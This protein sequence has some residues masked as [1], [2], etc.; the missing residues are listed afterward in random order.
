M[1][2]PKV[3]VIFGGCS[4]EYE[5]SLQSAAAVIPHIDRTKYEPVT[6]GITRNGEWFRF[7]G[8]AERIEAGAWTDGADCIPAVI[9]PDRAVR[10]LL[11]FTAGGVKAT[12]L[13]AAMPILHGRNGEDG[14]VQGLLELAGIP[15]VGC[16]AE[17]SAICMD[18]GRARKLARQ[19]GAAVPESFEICDGYDM[20]AMAIRAKSLGFPLFVKP[21]RAGSSYGV[22]KITEAG[23]LQ[24]AIENAFLYDAELIIEQAVPGV[25]TGCAVMG[26]D[27]LFIGELSETELADG[28]FDYEQKYRQRTAVVHVPARVSQAKADELKQ[29]AKTLYRAM[30][31]AGFARVDMFLT[32]AGEIYFNEI[33]TV[34]GFTAHSNYPKMMKAAGIAFDELVNRL[35]AAGLEPVRTV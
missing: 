35:I 9:S 18:K 4:P 27:E 22:S 29:T 25:E 23:Q 19:A 15:I 3:A 7:N 17:A 30:G 34:P 6:I 21:V 11:E 32:P 16:G 10:G 13:A 28:F 20:N 5:I 31:C 24:A 26:R 2:K 33:N 8:S 12:A 1:D 14:T